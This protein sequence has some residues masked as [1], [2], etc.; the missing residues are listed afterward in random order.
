MRIVLMYLGKKGKLTE[1]LRGMGSLSPEERPVMGALVNEAK[2][3]VSN[4]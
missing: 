3:E 4:E 2:E 1:I